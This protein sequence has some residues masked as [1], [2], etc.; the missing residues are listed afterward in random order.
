MK[1]LEREN[2]KRELS[3]ARAAERADVHAWASDFFDFA[4]N[5]QKFSRRD[6]ELAARIEA[7]EKAL[8]GRAGA[9]PEVGSATAFPE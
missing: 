3:I 9:E 5:F 4:R 2:H 6:T 7:L 1:Q 8:S